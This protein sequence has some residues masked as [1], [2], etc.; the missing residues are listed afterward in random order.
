M[1][2]KAYE[3]SFQIGGKLAS[4][5][6][7]TFSKA[8]SSLVDLKNQARQTQR[9][10]NQLGNDFRRGKIHQSQYTDSTERLVHE[11]ERLEREQNRISTLKTSFSNGLN[12]AKQVA[13]IAAVGTAYAGTGLALNSVKKAMNFEEQLSSIKAVTGISAEQ[14]SLVRQESLK[15]GAATKYSAFEAAQGFEELLKAGM[16]LETSLN[17]GLN[18]SLNLATAGGLELSESAAFVSDALNGFKKDS[19]TAADAANILAGAANASST[20]VR[21]IGL[22]LS[23]VG[24][25]ADGLGVSFKEVN[26]TLALFSNNSLK[27]SDAGTSFKTMLSNLVPMTDDAKEAFRKFGL[28]NKKGKN[29]LFDSNG[30]LKDMTEVAGILQKSF[31]H[32]NAEQRQ[33]VFYTMF[34][35]DAIRAAN[36]IYKEGAEGIEKMYDEMSKVTALDVAKAKMDNATGAVE[37]LSGAFETM[38]II[39]A[40]AL[41]PLIKEGAL[42]LADSFERNASAVEKF[43]QRTANTLGEVFEP[44]LLSKPVKPEFDGSNFKKYDE[45]MLKYKQD[46][47]KYKKFSGMDFGDKVVYSLD[48][49]S[50]KIEKWLDG[51]GGESV[52]K[53]FAKIGEIAA[54][55]WYEAFTGAL[56]AS[57]SNT[58]Q[59][60]LFAGIGMFA[61]A[62]FL[63]GG[64][65]GKGMIGAGKWGAGKLKGARVAKT[66]Q[67]AATPKVVTTI[68]PTASK[69]VTTLSKGGKVMQFPGT[70]AVE[71]AGKATGKAGSLKSILPKAGK[72]LGIAGKAALPLSIATELFNIFSAQDK[73]KATIQAG[74]GIAGGIGGAK[75]GALAGSFFGPVGTVLGGLI[76]GVGGYLGGR[77][78]GGKGTDAVRNRAAA[79][80][81]PLEAPG[82]TQAINT[83]IQLATKNLSLLAMYSGQ[84]S[85]WVVGSFTGIKSSAD[86]VKSNLDLLTMYTGQASGWLASLNGIQTAGQRVIRALNNLERRI[87]SVE[88]PSMSSRRLSFNG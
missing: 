48:E 65:L 27:G 70:K 75:V 12:T 8:S 86:K 55:A 41:N 35:S 11:L 66:L 58:A 76:G 17:G 10:L 7:S 3:M 39:G 85:G 67:V 77:W 5:F 46:L 71:T 31:K 64:L 59:G 52:N 9:A 33:Q 14:L 29:I 1:A 13:S 62:N 80:Q 61:A 15:Q 22:G 81:A 36:I 2:K 74:A 6:S 24:P 43:G 83:N 68:D 38:Q 20:G 88:L 45:L 40:E 25:V 44:F 56:K 57:V 30:E 63:T 84:A 54:K 72:V 34:G 28:V 73:T 16:S 47:E 60:N 37:Q 78:L 49:G 51:P 53:I 69:P 4:S 26:A 42:N 50:A 32:L 23:A 21:E 82:P 87:D 79:Q 19:M 18:S